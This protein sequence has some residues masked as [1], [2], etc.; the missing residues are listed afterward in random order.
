[1]AVKRATAAIFIWLL[2]W[3][4]VNVEGSRRLRK[5]TNQRKGAGLNPK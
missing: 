5:I 1:M 2:Y 4:D 3:L